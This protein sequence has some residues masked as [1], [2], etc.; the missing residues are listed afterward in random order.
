MTSP[1]QPAIVATNLRKSYGDKVVLDGIDLM[2]TEGTIFALLGP[3][4]ADKAAGRRRIA[5][6]LDQFDL[7]E[8]AG[9]R[10]RRTPAACAGGSIS[11]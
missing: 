11:R 2:I 3:N 4:G 7:T 5:D 6:L 8:A 9:K 1:M 10:C